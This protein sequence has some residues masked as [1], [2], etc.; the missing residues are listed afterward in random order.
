MDPTSSINEGTGAR[1]MGPMDS[2]NFLSGTSR[3][4]LR[5]ATAPELASL[6]LVDPVR[7]QLHSSASNG[8][9]ICPR[10]PRSVLP[11]QGLEIVKDSCFFAMHE[12]R[13]LSSSSAWFRYMFLLLC[14]RARERE[15]EKKTEGERSGGAKER[16]RR[17]GHGGM[18][19]AQ[20]GQKILKRLRRNDDHT[21]ASERSCGA[22]IWSLS[23]LRR[24]T[25]LFDRW[26]CTTFQ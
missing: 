19:S 12:P 10:R 4:D 11:D 13:F 7:A 9:R 5:P 16:L 2:C 26:A 1:L 20:E 18:E 14:E 21:P 25:E 24:M 3:K 17:E 22:W 15:R 23:G 6:R 8:K